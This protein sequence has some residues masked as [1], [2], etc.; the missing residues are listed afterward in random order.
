MQIGILALQGAT[1]PHVLKF[2]QLNF[3]AIEVKN[4]SDLKSVSGIILPG[5]ESTA[6]INLLHKTQL[7]D[8]LRDFASKKPT[9]GI[10][11]GSI[12]LAKNVLS[13]K[14]ESLR[15]LDITV[16]RN[17]YGRQLSSFIDTLKG[18]NSFKEVSLEGVFI[19]APKITEIGSD[20]GVLM[21]HQE[22]VVMVEERNLWASTFHPELSA[23]TFL[24][25]KFIEKCKKYG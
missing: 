7:W 14:Q 11:A 21:K 25:E 9:W 23:H 3:P 8:D 10:C 24:H 13:P 15:L 17:A 12:L 19:R 4:Y 18:V 20:V 16:E 1:E 5:G 22:E 6:M 2:K